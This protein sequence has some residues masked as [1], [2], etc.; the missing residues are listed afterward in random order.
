MLNAK[1]QISEVENVKLVMAYFMLL[2]T[3][4]SLYIYVIWL[5]VL[6]RNYPE[7]SAA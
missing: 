4:V 7:S 2:S 3:S 6:L 1:S 5:H